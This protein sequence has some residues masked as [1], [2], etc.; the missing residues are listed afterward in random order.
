MFNTYHSHSTEYVP[1]T[2]NVV[3]HRAPTDESIRLYGE[4]VEKAQRSLL[5]S[6][7]L[8]NSILDIAV[9]VTQ[10]PLTQS[11]LIWFRC[12]LNGQ[13]VEDSVK[14]P[15]SPLTSREEIIRLVIDDISTR[16]AKAITSKIFTENS[17][18]FI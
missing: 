14:L 2:K 18:E 7:E 15:Y 11:R 6:F 16:L 17:R 9:Q 3:E 5:D 12:V 4:L 10:D 8:K 13:V 1:Y